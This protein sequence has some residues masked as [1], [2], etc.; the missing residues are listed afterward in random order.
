MVGIASV[1]WT[2]CARIVATVNSQSFIRGNLSRATLRHGMFLVSL[3][4]VRMMRA[5]QAVALRRQFTP[6]R[7]RSD[8]QR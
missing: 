6:F 8:R 3:D 5:E 1:S 7:F 2:S 4:R